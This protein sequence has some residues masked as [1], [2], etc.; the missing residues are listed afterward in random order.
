MLLCYEHVSVHS[1]G[2]IVLLGVL[3]GEFQVAETLLTQLQAVQNQACEPPIG[4]TSLVGLAIGA[5]G[6]IAEK[7]PFP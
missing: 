5:S 4:D 2:L 3:H 7:H 1:V 6:R